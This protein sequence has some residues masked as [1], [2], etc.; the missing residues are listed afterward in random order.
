MFFQ[1]CIS[2]RDGTPISNNSHIG[3]IFKW[4]YCFSGYIIHHLLSHLVQ[5]GTRAC[6]QYRSR[7]KRG[8]CC[9]ERLQTSAT[10]ACQ[11]SFCMIWGILHSWRRREYWWR[12]EFNLKTENA[13]AFG[14]AL[15]A[16]CV[17]TMLW[18]YVRFGGAFAISRSSVGCSRW[19]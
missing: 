7:G 11:N 15:L 4:L 8:M 12:G 17:W 19:L 6:C 9:H 2:K 14:W 10:I 13:T 3:L 5:C 16:P 1:N 18:G